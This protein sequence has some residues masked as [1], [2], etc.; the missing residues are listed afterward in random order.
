MNLFLLARRQLL[1]RPLHSA[2]NL[3]L[4]A[5]GIATISLLLL[6]SRQLEDKLLHTAAGIDL[7]V[8]AK[9]SPLQLILS[10]VYH[11][12]IPTG[13]IAKAEADKLARHP[14]VASSIPLALGDNLQGFRIVGT[15]PDYLQLYGAKLAQGR[16]WQVSMEA[17]LGAKV[18]QR[19]GL[20]LGEEFASSHGLAAGGPLHDDNRYQVVGIL[21][22]SGSILDE[23]VLTDLQSVWD[24]H[25]HHASED[26][27]EDGKPRDITALLIRY[28]TPLAILALPRQINA[29]TAL[30]AASP[31]MEAMRLLN[32]LGFGL[33][34]LRAFAAVL[35][36]SAALSLF[37]A[38]YGNLRERRYD[39]AVMRLL[40][41]SRWRLFASVLL[42]GLLLAAAGAALGLLLGHGAAEAIG[43]AGLTP[44]LN[45]TGLIWLKEEAALLL[46]ALLVG[47]LAAL[48]PAIHAWRTDIAALL[49]ER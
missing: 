25:E 11:A 1:A 14:L 7:V 17:V 18:A 12:D 35:I 46:L 10:S 49:S 40:G 9:G 32:I 47:V 28:K 37:V 43:R 30:Q 23:L 15:T 48:L 21:A 16:P 31:A 20:K 38:L 33:D 45:L 44:G 26:D 13:N 27:A 3:L 39:L 34:A 5:L 6:F 42:E 19:S 22:P 36:F 2:L 4:L 29:E 41:S 24:M 8:G